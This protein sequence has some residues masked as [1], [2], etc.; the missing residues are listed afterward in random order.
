MGSM[1]L[2]LSSFEQATNSLGKVLERYEREP[3][4]LVVQDSVIQRFEYTYGMAFKI[5]KRFLALAG[6]NAEEIDMMSFQDIIRTGNAKGLLMSDVG[7]WSDYR[8]KRKIT[9]HTYDNDK[10]ETV[11][12][13]VP[14]FYEEAK[15]LLERLKE[16]NRE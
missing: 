8:N 3:D 12:E 11:V 1:V 2:D 15:Y 16:R 7:V 6:E 5:L 10:A 9:S 4:D 14:Q 13:I